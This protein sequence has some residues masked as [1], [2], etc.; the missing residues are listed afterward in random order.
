MI[1]L[2]FLAS[3]LIAGACTP[4]D[5]SSATSKTTKQDGT[6]V[7][8]PTRPVMAPPKPGLTIKMPEAG[9]EPRMVFDKEFH[10]FGEVDEGDELECLFPFRNEGKGDLVII[11]MNAHC[12]CTALWVEVEGKL[13]IYGDPIPPGAKGI[14][15]FVLKTAGFQNDKPSAG[16]LYTNDPA[17][18]GLS[19]QSPVTITGG[20][21]FGVVSVKV[22]SFIRKIFEFEPT[23]ALTLGAILNLEDTKK[24]IVLKNNRGKAFEINGVEPATDPDVKLSWK[25]T[26][27]TNSRWEVTVLIPKG[28]PN[29]SL[30]KI[31]QLKTTPALPNNQIY[32][33]G[34]VV[35]AV[36]TNPPALMAFGPITKGQATMRQITVK[37]HHPSIPLKITNVQFFDIDDKQSLKPAEQKTLT[38]LKATVAEMPDGK[39]A[40]I[41]IECGASMPPGVWSARLS[42]NTGVEGGPS[43]ISLPVSGY[44]R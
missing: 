41:T 7:A 21:Q 5:G 30:T 31:F 22:H 40:K 1:T 26:D 16:D 25:P 23:N 37:N 39:E 13:Y 10:E 2:G 9:K 32:I 34:T 15:H 29:A 17:R 14:V 20:P 27:T 44:V 12:G 8:P 28:R 24:T 38:N 11:N 36:E 43:T 42:F 33:M 35:G 4:A 6:H 19:T 3:L 18:G